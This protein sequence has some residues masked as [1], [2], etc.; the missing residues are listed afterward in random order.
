V[1]LLGVL[2]AA[3]IGVLV[4][5]VA[6]DDPEPSS[7]PTSRPLERDAAVPSTVAPVLSMPEF[8][9]LVVPT[10]PTAD[11]PADG[12]VDAS[13]LAA[14]VLRLT[15]D[16]PRRATTHVELGYGGYAADVT[17]LRDPVNDRFEISLDTGAGPSWAIIDV[18]NSTVYYSA[19]RREWASTDDRID[20]AGL[21]YDRMGEVYERLLDGPLRPDTIGAATVDTTGTVGLDDGTVAEAYRV[22]LAGSTIP[23]WQL[24]YLAPRSDFD[25]SDRPTTLV[26]DVYVADDVEVVVGVGDVG[27]IAQVVRHEL[28]L[29]PAPIPVT[30]PATGTVDIDPS[31]D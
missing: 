25:P 14:D 21:P 30:L 17:I 5:A 1:A 24:Y 18:P 16:V 23:L 31:D 9:G 26:Y 3:A 13:V 19:D 4:V 10:L 8:E 11:S 2:A 20:V 22:A 15:A 27:G 7:T 12:R 29:L 28:E 6:D